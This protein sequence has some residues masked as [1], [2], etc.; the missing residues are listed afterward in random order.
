MK[1]FFAV[2][3]VL[4]LCIYAHGET[5]DNS[6]PVDLINCFGMTIDELYSV[7]KA[8]YDE[9]SNGDSMTVCFFMEDNDT[10]TAIYALAD[11]SQYGWNENEVFYFGVNS[12]SY[13]IAGYRD[14]EPF[15]TVE[16]RLYAEEWAEVDTGSL[17]KWSQ[18]RFAD[19]VFEKD[20]ESLHCRL[21]FFLEDS[22]G[23]STVRYLM[24]EATPLNIEEE[25]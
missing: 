18:A 6:L 23:V 16:S 14:G 24:C 1:R 20:I 11:D 3:I 25:Q 21:G 12:P 4:F 9:D 15:E 10:V 5:A 22:D 17:P 8:E 7:I 19:A 2:M 13:C